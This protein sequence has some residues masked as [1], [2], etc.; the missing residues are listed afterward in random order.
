MKIKIDFSAVGDV[1]K[2]KEMI[3]YISQLSERDPRFG[4]I[5]LNKI[6]YYADFGAYRE[7][8]HPITE[9]TYQHLREGPAPKELLQAIDE[10]EDEGAIKYESPLYYTHRQKR[11]VPCRGPD[12]KHFKPKELRIVKDVVKALWDLNAT[13][14]RN[15]S[16][17]EWGWRLSD[18]GETIHYRT[19]WLSPEPLTQE[20]IRDG[21]R[22]WEEMSAQ[23]VSGRI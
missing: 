15:L 4:A 6:L 22:L 2:L 18:D 12:L 20:Q 11:I 1:T 14:V 5:K 8:G 17:E 16:H 9:A 19:A 13:Q 21:I 7:L 3:L 23:S 10:L